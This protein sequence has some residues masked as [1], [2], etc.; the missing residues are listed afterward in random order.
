M[1]QAPAPMSD[2]LSIS[3]A[4][5]T[6]AALSNPVIETTQDEHEPPSE[7]AS[8]DRFHRVGYFELF[9]TRSP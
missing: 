1:A 8:E 7:G 4:P 3:D 5:D 2:A 6:D 9:V